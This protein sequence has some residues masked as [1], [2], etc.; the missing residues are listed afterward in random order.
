MFDPLPHPASE[1]PFYR[2]GW[3][4][5]LVATQPDGSGAP[6]FLSYPTI[7]TVFTPKTPR[8]ANRSFLGLVKQA[9]GRQILIDQNNNTLYY[10]IHVN[11]AYADFIHAN[12]LDT[13]DALAAYPSDP[14][15]EEPGVSAG[16]GRVQVRLAA[17]RRRRRVHRRA[18]RRFHL[19]DDHGADAGARPHDAA[20]HGG[21]HSARSPPPC[22]CSRCTSCSPCRAIPSSSGPR[23]EHSTA[24]PTASPATA[25][26]TSRRRCPTRTRRLPTR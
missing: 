2:G 3:Q 11:Q 22:G 9:G 6:A 17:G 5:F 8:P 13:A 4:N 18:D 16:G 15:E 12:G 26:G 1:C 24:R 7:D 14:R 21:S 10:G 23:F 19:D 25:S 20:D